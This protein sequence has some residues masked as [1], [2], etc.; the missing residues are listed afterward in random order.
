VAATIH[1]PLAVLGFFSL[2]GMQFDLSVVA[3]ILAVIGYSVN[4][5]IV[6]FDRIRQGFRR[7]RRGTPIEIVN[8][9]INETLSRTILT[10]GTTQL[11]VIAL[12]LFGGPALTGF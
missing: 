10:S 12:L 11:V 7:H 9:A 5:T 1:D 4:D 8:G 6:V 2:T 3:A